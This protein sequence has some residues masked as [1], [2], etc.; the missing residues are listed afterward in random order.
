[1]E[2]KMKKEQKMWLVDDLFP[3]LLA[4]EKLCTIRA[5]NRDF[6]TGPLTFESKTGQVATVNVKEVRHKK[7]CELT[8]KEAQ[9]DGAQNAADM[10]RALKRFYPYIGP[11]S[12]ITVVLYD[13][14]EKAP[15]A[16]RIPPRRPRGPRM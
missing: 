14:P 6:T 16:V 9:M 10:A 2:S 8:D 12:D 1:M 13:P 7:L 3:P 11:D 4:G 15:L 5:G